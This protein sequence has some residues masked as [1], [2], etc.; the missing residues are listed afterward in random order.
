MPALLASLI[1]LLGR[2][3]RVLEHSTKPRPQSLLCDYT[4][5]VPLPALHK[6]IRALGDTAGTAPGNLCDTWRRLTLEV[7][8]SAAR[9]LQVMLT[10]N[11]VL[12]SVTAD[13]KTLTGVQIITHCPAAMAQS[14]PLLAFT[15]PAHATSRELLL[16]WNPYFRLIHGNSFRSR[17]R[18]LL[19]RTE[20][21]QS[22]EARGTQYWKLV[23]D[24]IF[25][26]L[27]P[28]L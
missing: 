3:L 2:F 26:R 11:G 23:A 17:L 28:Q 8:L 16:R 18:Q 9:D 15:Q 12:L 13:F 24:P 19:G 22:H 1:D 6:A 4:T 20:A 5:D 27:P 14:L 25:E 21:H 10:T 7:E